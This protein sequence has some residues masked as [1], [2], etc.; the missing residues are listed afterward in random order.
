M[1]S[2]V[3]NGRV[4][5]WQPIAKIYTYGQRYLHSCICVCI[6]LGTVLTN[7]YCFEAKINTDFEKRGN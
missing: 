3:P 2:I 7:V 6:C 5:K 4:L 1:S